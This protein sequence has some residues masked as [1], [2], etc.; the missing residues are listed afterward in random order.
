M[1][2]TVNEAYN[3]IHAGQVKKAK[4]LLRQ[5]NADI[6]TENFTSEV[7]TEFRTKSNPDDLRKSRMLDPSL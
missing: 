5:T 1:K 6:L 2:C 3:Y 7:T 4:M